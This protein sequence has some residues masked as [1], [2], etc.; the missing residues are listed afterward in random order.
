MSDD[1]NLIKSL[2]ADQAKLLAELH[3]HLSQSV[4][5]RDGLDRAAPTVLSNES[6]VNTRKMLNTTMRVLKR[7]QEMNLLLASALIM[8]CSSRDFTGWQAQFAMMLGSDPQDVL[9][10]MMADK[11]RGQP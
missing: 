3:T 2:V 7:Q 10:K 5:D 9:R 6:E 1:L 4:R 11:L 8:V